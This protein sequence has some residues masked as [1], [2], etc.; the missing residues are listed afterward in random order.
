MDVCV[1]NASIVCTVSINVIV[2][3]KL[4][5]ESFELT[6]LSRPDANEITAA[7]IPVK[8]IKQMSQE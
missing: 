3:G 8:T 2:I 5:E 7:P 1:S 6:K 4:I